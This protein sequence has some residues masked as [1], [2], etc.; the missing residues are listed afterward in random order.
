MRLR[1]IL[2]PA[3]DNSY[4]PDRYFNMVSALWRTMDNRLSNRPYL[5]GEYTI[6]DI[7]CYLW[8]IYLDPPEGID[9]FLNIRRWREQIAERPAVKRTYDKVRLLET[10]YGMDEN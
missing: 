9:A 6:T 7:A 4:A 2:A 8:I 1:R 3:L 10:G 5:A